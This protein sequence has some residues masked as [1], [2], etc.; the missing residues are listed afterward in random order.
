MVDWG[1]G[2]YEAT[3]AELDPV[4]HVVVKRAA[5]SAGDD[6]VDLACGTGNAALLAAARGARV[7]GVDAA[8]RLL[9][10]ARERA[11][12][13]GVVLDLREGDLLALPVSDAA[14]DAVLSVFGVIFA[15]E[16]AQSLREIARIL[17]PGGRALLSAWV[18]AGPIDAMLGAMGR[19]VGRATRA[20]ARQRFAWSDP[21]AVVPLTDGTGL[22]LE[23]TTSGQLAIRGASPEAY[24]AA[25]QE[26]PMTIAMRPVVQQAG[27][28]AEVREAMT[29]VLRKANED[30]SGFLVHSPYVVHELRAG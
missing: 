12:A 30:P 22:A 25:G 3:A 26:H 5:L 1:A 7:I 4:A 15:P 18:P 9:E 10:V 20:P 27:V 29:T 8:P 16:P 24:V 21:G 17:R 14:A 13:Q 11:Q 23:A 19:I 2:K 6:V 28:E